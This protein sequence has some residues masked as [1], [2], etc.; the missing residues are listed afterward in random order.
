M[1]RVKRQKIHD[2]CHLGQGG[3]GPC[4]FFQ[5]KYIFWFEFSGHMIT[6]IHESDSANDCSET[7]IS[8]SW[9]LLENVLLFFIRL[10]TWSFTKA[11][12]SMLIFGAKLL[13][14]WDALIM[15]RIQTQLCIQL[16]LW[17]WLWDC[18]IKLEFT[19]VVLDWFQICQ[20]KVRTFY[21]S[22]DT[23]YFGRL[24]QSMWITDPSRSRRWK[25][26]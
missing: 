24:V 7:K 20:T 19:L 10:L 4:L 22:D 26:P 5:N 6:V 2:C 25:L 9:A 13:S 14:T 3:W 21:F 12:Y 11:K 1:G 15:D 8:K 16:K 17:I 23:R 18:V